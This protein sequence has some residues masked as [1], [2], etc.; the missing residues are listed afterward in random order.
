MKNEKRWNNYGDGYDRVIILGRGRGGDGDRWRVEVQRQ[1]H[2]KERRGQRFTSKSPSQAFMPGINEI[3]NLNQSK[4][5]TS[6]PPSIPSFSALR[7]Y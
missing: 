4:Q 3:M 2:W 1:I 5:S 6:H 7:I